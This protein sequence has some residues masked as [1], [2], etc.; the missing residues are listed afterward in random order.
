MSKPISYFET[1][2]NKKLTDLFKE[3]N[4]EEEENDEDK[5]QYPKED[6]G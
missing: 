4:E 3:L 5:I 6:N 2:K 1:K